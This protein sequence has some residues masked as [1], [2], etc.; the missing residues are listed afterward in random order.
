MSQRSKDSA[1]NAS[2]LPN[3]NSIGGTYPTFKSHPRSEAS[4]QI[5]AQAAPQLTRSDAELG[6]ALAQLQNMDAISLLEEL[7]R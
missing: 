4:N 6:V 3:S 1:Q 7:F 2:E 5:T